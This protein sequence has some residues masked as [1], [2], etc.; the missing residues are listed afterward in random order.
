MNKPIKIVPPGDA[1]PGD[2]PDN[3]K[4]AAEAPHKN[5]LFE[6]ASGAFGFDRLLPA[7]VPAKLP[8]GKA[9][10]MP[11]PAKRADAADDLRATEP[12]PDNAVTRSQPPVVIDADARPPRQ[13]EVGGQKVEFGGKLHPI[14]RAHLREQG[15]IDPELGSGGLVEE[16]RIVKRQVLATVEAEG[17]SKSRRVLICSPHPGEGKTFC[18]TNLAIA[19]AGERQS[20]VLLVDADFGKPSIMKTFGLDPAPGLMDALRDPSIEVEKLVVGTD[21]PGLWIL[22]AGERSGSDA[23]YLASERTWQVLN[24]LTR[25]AH[26]RIV[27][28]D[29]PPALAASP[30]AELAKH[31]GQALLVA[32]ADCTAR[33]AL[34]DAVDLLSGCADIRLLL[35]DVTFSPSGRKFG[36]YYGYGE[37]PS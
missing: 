35:N 31:C 13:R 11:R 25:G 26:D 36:K 22:P 27:I 34:E 7:R 16:F 33:A 12:G 30:A 4:E 23:E 32:R 9:V 37:S 3:G 28:F 29:S 1:K 17:T 24:R 5:S 15:M 8:E 6:R 21:I 14:S 2:G 10:R 18:A 19:L 20:E